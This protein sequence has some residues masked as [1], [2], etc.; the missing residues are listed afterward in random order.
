MGIINNQKQMLTKRFT[1]IN[2]KEREKSKQKHT[3]LRANNNSFGNCQE[4]TDWVSRKAS[5]MDR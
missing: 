4:R 1:D 3:I 5:W 2:R